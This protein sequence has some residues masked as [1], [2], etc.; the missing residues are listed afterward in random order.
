MGETERIYSVR[1]VGD[2]GYVVTYRRID[3]FHV[4]DLSDPDDP[5]LAG[6]LKLPGYSTYLHP[7]GDDRVL[8][9]GEQDGKVKLVVFDVSDPADPTIAESR[10]LDARWSAVARSHH[11]FLLDPRHEVFFLPTETGGQ[12]FDYDLDR[13]TRIDVRNPRRAVY[14]GDHLYVAGDDMV[15][16]DERTWERVTR[17][18]LY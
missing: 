8:G 17:V 3:P 9:V 7:L 2:R 1:F 14:V 18:D 4:L 12:V 10:V 16:V 13:V 6:E 15:V 5:E 11:A